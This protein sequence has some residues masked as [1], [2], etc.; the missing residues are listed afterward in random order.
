MNFENFNFGEK[1]EEILHRKEIVMYP[2]IYSLESVHESCKNLGIK[3]LIS[4]CWDIDY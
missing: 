4:K 3:Y 2:S 1:K